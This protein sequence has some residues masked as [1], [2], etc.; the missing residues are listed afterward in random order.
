MEKWR[1]GCF[2]GLVALLT[3]TILMG[4]GSVTLL[5]ADAACFRSLTAKIP[6]YPN[7][8]IT[9]ERYTLLR[10]FGL[11]ETVMV[12]NSN[13]DLPVVE[14]WYTVVAERNRRDLL[15]FI[16]AAQWSAARNVDGM[17]TQIVLNGICG[18]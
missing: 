4:C 11:G 13:D 18:G 5:V 17:G 10:P 9:Q 7:A 2:V 12:L 14:Q 3:A 1:K 8:A 16:T 6:V 15:N